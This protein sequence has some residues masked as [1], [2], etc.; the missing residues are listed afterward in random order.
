MKSYNNT[1]KHDM[2][3]VQ[4]WNGCQIKEKLGRIG[5]LAT[6]RHAQ[7]TNLIVCQEGFMFKLAPHVHDSGILSQIINRSPARAIPCGVNAM[8]LGLVTCREAKLTKVL[9]R[10]GSNIGKELDF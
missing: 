3:A 7:Q 9:G 2:F 5:V 4:M 10:Y 6:V 1:S 8:N